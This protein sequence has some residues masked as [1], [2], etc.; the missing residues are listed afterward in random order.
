[1]QRTK[2]IARIGVVAASAIAVG[3]G[4]WFSPAA[5]VQPAQDESPN[6]APVVRE[7]STVTEESFT[8]AGVRIGTTNTYADST[9]SADTVDFDE[10]PRAAGDPP[11]ASGS[12]GSVSNS[13]C[14][15]VTVT[16]VH[17]TLTGRTAFK[18][19]TWTRWCWVRATKVI[20]NV[21]TGYTFSTDGFEYWRGMIQDNKHFYDWAAGVA[22]KSG[23]FHE[24]VGSFENC[25]LK[26]GC[27]SIAYPHNIIRSHTNGTWTWSATGLF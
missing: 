6:A 25:I 27:I 7:Q 13:G 2:F 14:R 17:H 15:K 22:P 11:S 18:F 1:M 3:G 23:Y 20:S 21:T 19:I 26:Y 24:K 12:G 16:N 9:Q 10:S 8:F 4:G 5:A